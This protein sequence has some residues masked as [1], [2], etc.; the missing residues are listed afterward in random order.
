MSLIEQRLGPDDLHRSLPIST[1]LWFCE[2]KVK[3]QQRESRVLSF[4]PVVSFLPHATV[5]SDW[6]NVCAHARA[7]AQEKEKA[8]AGG[9]RRLSWCLPAAPASILT[10]T[11]ILPQCLS[12]FW[13][14]TTMIISLCQASAQSSRQLH[15]PAPGKPCKPGPGELHS[16]SRHPSISSEGQKRAGGTTTTAA[17]GSWDQSRHPGHGMCSCGLRWG[18]GR[19]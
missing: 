12:W 4:A 11:R 9:W 5:V 1:F 15:N 8:M 18:A 3:H 16:A 17:R 14:R 13:G 6:Q 2:K 7:R 10:W 19:V